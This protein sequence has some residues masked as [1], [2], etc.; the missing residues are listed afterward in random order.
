MPVPITSLSKP[1]FGSIVRGQTVVKYSQFL[2][3]L[4]L[5]K[6]VCCQSSSFLGTVGVEQLPLRLQ[7]DS[8]I[9]C[10]E[11]TSMSQFS[12]IL[13]SRKSTILLLLVLEREEQ[14]VPF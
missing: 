1:F 10:V 2:S 8:K 12:N 7:C 13:L 5:R 14:L 11:C 3:R 6:A 4:L 9:E